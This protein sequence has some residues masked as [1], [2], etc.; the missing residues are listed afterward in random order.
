MDR[1]GTIKALQIGLD[2]SIDII[3]HLNKHLESLGQSQD[4]IILHEI[5]KLEQL[6][7]YSNGTIFN[8]DH[9]LY[10]N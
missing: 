2:S 5:E 4:P 6:L 3:K 1:A 10:S 7:R 8:E 9:P